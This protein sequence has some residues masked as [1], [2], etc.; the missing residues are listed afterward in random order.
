MTE[1]SNGLVGKSN[2]L[3][4]RT[5]A[6]YSNGTVKGKNRR[7]CKGGEA[8]SRQSG[9]LLLVLLHRDVLQADGWGDVIQPSGRV[10]LEGN[11]RGGGS[12]SVVQ[13]ATTTV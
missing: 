6:R 8:R 5:S 3:G 4:G 12:F 2:G 10:P 11:C 13:W 9:Q 7:L 1:F